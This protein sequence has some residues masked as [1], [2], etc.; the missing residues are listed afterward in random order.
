MQEAVRVRA[1]QVG[2]D[3]FAERRLARGFIVTLLRSFRG[4]K[5]D[6]FLVPS[7]MTRAFVGFVISAPRDRAN[8]IPWALSVV[9]HLNLC[10]F[11]GDEV[12]QVDD[13]NGGGVLPGWGSVLIHHLMGDV[14]LVGSSAPCAGR[15]RV[16][17]FRVLRR[18][19]MAFFDGIERRDV[20]QSGVHTFNGREFAVSCGVRKFS[21]VIFFF[22]RLCYARSS[23]LFLEDC[24]FA[25]RL[26]CNFG[27]VRYEFPP[28]V[29][30][31][32]VELPCLCK[33]GGV[34]YSQLRYRLFLFN[35]LFAL[36]VEVD[37]DCFHFLEDYEGAI[38]DRT[39]FGFHRVF[40]CQDLAC[41]MVVGTYRVVR[42]RYREPPSAANCRTS[43]PV[44]TVAME[45]FATVSAGPLVAVVV[46]DEVVGAVNF[47]L[48]WDLLSE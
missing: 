24:R 11:R 2:F 25:V 27:I 43:S 6:M 33:G 7:P 22:R 37:G 44:P 48:K 15:V 45:H 8:V 42:D 28:A 14:V 23:A 41:V 13:T 40:Y 12:K 32:W 17:V 34:I 47:P 5:V 39:I 19:T 16:N 38:C 18:L 20:V 35:C 36:L 46:V 9:F 1:I 26:C 10:P 31:P 3:C 4:A 29:E 30:R 21:L